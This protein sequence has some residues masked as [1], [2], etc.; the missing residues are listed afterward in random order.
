MDNKQL[1]GQYCQQFKMGGIIGRIDQLVREAEANASGYLD[2]TAR[3]LGTEAE[4]LERNDIKKRLKTAKP[5][6]SCDLSTYLITVLITG[7]RR[8]V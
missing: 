8:P 5:P 3:L 1:I 6:R 2:Y 7:C 4:H